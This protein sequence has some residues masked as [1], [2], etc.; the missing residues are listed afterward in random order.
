MSKSLNSLDINERKTVD[1]I[2]TPE[3]YTL[4]TRMLVTRA[5]IIRIAVITFLLN[6]KAKNGI[7]RINI[8]HSIFIKLPLI[9]QLRTYTGISDS[10]AMDNVGF[11]MVMV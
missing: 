4:H 11:F 2:K 5:A 9:I 10:I 6:I 8:D 1:A 7:D 3:I